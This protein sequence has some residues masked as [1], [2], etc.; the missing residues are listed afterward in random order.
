VKHQRSLTAVELELD[1]DITHFNNDLVKFT[2]ARNDVKQGFIAHFAREK[3]IP[4]DEY[5]E[6]KDL[7]EDN[8]RIGALI[9]DRS[10]RTVNVCNR[11]L[12]ETSELWFGI[13]LLL[14]APVVFFSF[15][16]RLRSLSIHRAS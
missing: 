16:D 5:Q 9:I 1:E 11:I 10:S 4:V 12:K 7:I 14:P 6:M 15:I 13:S 8:P 2:D 3:T